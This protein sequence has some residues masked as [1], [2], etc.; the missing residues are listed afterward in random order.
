MRRSALDQIVYSS[1]QNAGKPHKQRQVRI[2]ALVLD[3]V[4]I[5]PCDAGGGSQSH[6]RQTALSKMTRNAFKPTIGVT[7]FAC[8]SLRAAYSAT[9]LRIRLAMLLCRFSCRAASIV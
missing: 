1:P 6:L 3:L 4:Q 5:Q 2:S 8:A 7:V 9:A